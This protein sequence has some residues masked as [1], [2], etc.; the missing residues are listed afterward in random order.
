MKIEVNGEVVSREPGPGQCLRTF[1]RDL[2]WFGVKKGCD[3]GDCGACTVHVDGVP[4]HS[5]VFPAFR[6]A[7]R[8]VTTV[9][10]LAHDGEPHPMQ[11]NFLAAQGFQ[12]GFCTAGM[13][14][15]AAGLDEDQLRDLPRALKG[16]LCR[17]T[18]Y[19]SIEDA[20]NGV[21]H[22]EEAVPG[23]SCGRNLPAPAGPEVV[24]G[25]ARYT[26]DVAVDGLLHLK[27]LRSPHAHARIA[28]IDTSAALAIP[29]VQAVLTF[30][31]SPR[32]LFSTATHENPDTDPADM[33][34]F[35][36]VVRFVG[37]RV[38]AVVADSVAAAEEGCRR[39]IVRYEILP[40]VFDPEEAMAP[41]APIL[42]DKGPEQRI[43]RAGRNVAGEVHGDVG[44]VE[45]GFAQADVVHEQS[46]FTQRVQHVPLETHA[47]IAWLDGS[48]RLIVRSS[49]QTPFLTRRAL[50]DVFELP[51]EK[52]RVF[53]GRV[54]GGF[55][56]K[57]EMLTEDV[58]ALATL[59]TGRPVQLEYTREEMFVGATT[60]HP[61][62]VHVKVG[63]RRDGTLT[64]IRLRTVSNTGAYGNHA[65]ETLFHGSNES[66]AVYRCP[67]KKVD[68]Y[69][70][71][72]NTPPAG[73]FR[74][75]GLSQTI[76]AVESAMD[77]LARELGM[78]PIAFRERNI[79][80]PG[81]QLVSFSTEPDDVQI[82]SYGLDQC[83]ALVGEAL[84][85]GK[86]APPGDDWLVG[87]GVALAMLD[88]IPPHGHWADARITLLADGGYELA[89]GTAEFGNGTTTVH[90]QIAATV[91][92]T[93]VDRIRIVQADTDLVGHDTGAFGSTGTMVAGQAT[94]RAAEALREQIVAAAAEHAEVDPS[95]CDLI[96]DDVRCGA[97]RVALD[98]V[99]A[100]GRELS[101]TGTYGGTPRSVAFNVQGF[102][103]AVN[104]RTGE[105][106]FLQ[107]VHAADAGR[108]INPMQCRGQIE[109]SVAQGLGAAMY[110]SVIV[111]DA[112]YV[113]TRTLRNYCVPAFGD[114][115]RTEV[116]FADT[117]DAIGPLGAKSMSESPFLPVAPALAN[118]VRDAT[119]IRFGTLPLARDHVCLTLMRESS[120]GA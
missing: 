46:Y 70:V 107:S 41:G 59:R 100:A 15:T 114:V 84:R 14:M 110:E 98:D 102:R 64:A 30:E 113:T 42:H 3:A 85:R 27:L 26:L 11:R 103:V 104:P 65:R 106:R 111:D 10:G 38:A 118:A 52:V 69:A 34:V 96:G 36:D 81:D 12:C 66:I 91:L 105:I 33:L 67:N 18:G 95:T 115:P 108:V 74:G 40:A 6:A 63:A 13:L 23:Q 22:V 5:C 4:V 117:S 2:G 43:A 45:A 68:G 78:D 86:G 116:H 88:A 31:D 90:Q 99:R 8:R 61:V 35:D 92:G 50:C 93:V 57:Q 29:G 120:G 19:R 77:E 72:T 60:R 75:Y 54:G 25:K 1:L 83:L 97:V 87:Q 112:G 9:E 94:L 109:G 20:I 47:S 51:L 48:G 73:A 62:T 82:G 56:G 16:N 39:L 17:C 76:F 49:T 24:T 44:D 37:Q 7:G 53:C 119:G 32:R 80:R 71:Y 55:G 101:A 21:V 79:I 28:A 58:V 89:V